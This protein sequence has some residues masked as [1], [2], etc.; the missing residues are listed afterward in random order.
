MARGV[1]HALCSKKEM[2]SYRQM[3]RRLR[4]H[5]K[6]PEIYHAIVTKLYNDPFLNATKM[7]VT[8]MAFRLTL[9]GLAMDRIILEVYA[10]EF[11]RKK[12]LGPHPTITFVLVTD[13]EG[14]ITQHGA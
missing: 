6:T 11:D 14:Q 2:F 9:A 8:D 13:K 3:E 1:F 12:T 7:F 10:V 5:C 4:A